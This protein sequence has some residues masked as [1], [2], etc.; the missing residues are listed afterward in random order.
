MSQATATIAVIFVQRDSSG[1]I[2]RTP[3]TFPQSEENIGP[4][5]DPGTIV[6]VVPMPCKGEGQTTS[7]GQRKDSPLRL[8]F[9]RVSEFAIVQDTRERTIAILP[10]IAG[11]RE[12]EGYVPKRHHVI[13]IVRA[14]GVWQVSYRDSESKLSGVAGYDVAPITTSWLEMA[15]ADI[16]RRKSL[17][18]SEEQRDREFERHEREAERLRAF[19][20][21]ETNFEPLVATPPAPPII[22]SLELASFISRQAATHR[23]IVK[24]KRV[25]GSKPVQYSVE[26]WNS[27][28]EE[29]WRAALEDALRVWEAAGRDPDHEP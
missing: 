5:I 3:I 26:N 18:K 27:T 11:D 21:G 1:P 4:T 2:V 28:P 9:E 17:K 12:I 16:R 7:A 22:A 8:N 25:P 23:L 29:T 20:A 6:D 24:Y 19:K 13:R 15:K 10:V 14:V